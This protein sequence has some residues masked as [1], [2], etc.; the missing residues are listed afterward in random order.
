MS[1]YPDFDKHL[2]P[3]ERILSQKIQEHVTL[4]ATDVSYRSTEFYLDTF[5]HRDGSASFHHRTIAD[6]MEA[7]GAALSAA[8]DAHAREI[9]VK[10]DFNP[11]TALP[12]NPE[13]LPKSITA[14]NMMPNKKMKRLFREAVLNYNAKHGEFPIGIV[15]TRFLPIDVERRVIYISVDD[16]LVKRQKEARKSEAEDTHVNVANTV[17]H[18]Q[19][20]GIIYIIT[21]VGIKEAFRI[22]V[23][24]LLENNLFEGRQLVFMSDGAKEIKEYAEKFF[25]WRPYIL[26]LDWF[27]LA[28]RIRELIS[29]C[30]KMPKDD[31]GPIIK[32]ILNYLWVG[33]IDGAITY[34]KSFEKSIIKNKA[35]HEEMIAYLLRKKEN[36]CCCALRRQFK[37]RLSSNTA[38]KANDLVVADRQKHNGMSWSYDG[39][40][41]LALLSATC[42]NNALSLWITEGKVSLNLKEVGWDLEEPKAA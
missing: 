16:V 2:S 36:I 11:D 6:N 22:L 42:R 33:N 37:L 39:S 5:L 20:D 26:I 29:M 1:L 7:S 12:N 15:P 13:K 25:F 41:A 14:P 21:A 31:K 10:N 8:L 30:L 35:I 4:L 19:V 24:L 9:L 40:G 38:E 17:I 3:K 28:K 32:K 34:I 18:I 23:A 27:H